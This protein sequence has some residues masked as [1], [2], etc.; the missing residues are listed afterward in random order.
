MVHITFP[1]F[2]ENGFDPLKRHYRIKKFA[3]VI[4]L[5]ETKNYTG[6]GSNNELIKIIYQV[7]MFG[8]IR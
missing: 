8:E 4:L 2:R 3:M 5:F 7:S 6:K 1:G